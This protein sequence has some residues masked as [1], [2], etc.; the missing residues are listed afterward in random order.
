MPTQSGRVSS[1]CMSGSK[2]DFPVYALFTKGD[3]VAGFIEYFASLS[4]QGRRQVWGATFQTN[5]KTRNLVGEVPME[6]RRSRRA[7]QL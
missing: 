2:V 5:D 6:Y 4:D 1:N 3:L 7:P